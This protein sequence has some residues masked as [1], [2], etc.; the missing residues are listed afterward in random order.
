MFWNLSQLSFVSYN[1]KITSVILSR[2][3]R[4]MKTTPL[5]ISIR[6]PLFQLRRAVSWCHWLPANRGRLQ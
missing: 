4:I 5:T 2:R 1:P 3:L 6:I